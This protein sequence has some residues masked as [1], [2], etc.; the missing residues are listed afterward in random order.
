MARHTA[1]S[2]K[3]RKVEIL[4]IQSEI[5]TIQIINYLLI[6]LTSTEQQVDKGVRFKKSGAFSVCIFYK[7]LPIKVEGIGHEINTD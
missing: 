4:V 7:M 6:Y 3:I 1:K 5:F 2:H